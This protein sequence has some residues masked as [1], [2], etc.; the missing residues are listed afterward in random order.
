MYFVKNELEQLR[1]SANRK[2]IAIA[3]LLTSAI[4]LFFFWL[5]VASLDN[6]TPRFID[7]TLGMILAFYFVILT[8]YQCSY[9]LKSKDKS[10][11]IIDELGIQD[12]TF[13]SYSGK[14]VWEEIEEIL[15]YDLQLKSGGRE[16]ALGII[17][18]KSQDF[19]QQFSFSWQ[20]RKV[21]IAAFFR[22]PTT[23]API[24]I[25]LRD[26]QLSEPHEFE[27]EIR[28]RIQK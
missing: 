24:N 15:F 9:L 21:A 5:V 11:L 13:F 12:N 25:L 2:R 10:A 19:L 18:K 28:E 1:F 17:P 16:R 3:A 14:I 6:A 8:F 22:F 27:R 20:V 26:L 7:Y 4:A 23:Q